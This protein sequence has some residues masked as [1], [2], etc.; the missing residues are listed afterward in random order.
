MVAIS[1][2]LVAIIIPFTI[3]NTKAVGVL[4]LLISTSTLLI[5]WP[6]N[7]V[8]F[9]LFLPSGILALKH[10]NEEKEKRRKALGA[11]LA[12][13][14]KI[15]TIYEWNARLHDL[16]K[17]LKTYDHL[18]PR[19]IRYCIDEI[20]RLTDTSPDGWK[21]KLQDLKDRLESD[22]SK[23]NLYNSNITTNSSTGEDPK[24][25]ITKIIIG[26]LAIIIVGSAI[27]FFYAQSRDNNIG[28]ISFPV[29]M[30]SGND[31]TD[32][33]GHDHKDERPVA[34]AG[35]DQ[36]IACTVESCK[37]VTLDGSGSSDP[38]GDSL[39]YMWTSKGNLVQLENSDTDHP[40]F[41]PDCSNSGDNITYKFRLTV[42]DGNKKDSDTTARTIECPHQVS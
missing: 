17:A 32:S 7:V 1:L 16:H 39:N 6:S 29:T 20:D 12:I 4:I 25:K 33:R 19:D 22:F 15:H 36:T 10:K 40:S 41:T 8:G 2:N 23:S 14:E 18:L 24:Q 27:A 26:G 31:N 35:D 9:L 30:P 38:D 13:I 21:H 37:S 3:N 34:D 11:I 28:S 5:S 42:D